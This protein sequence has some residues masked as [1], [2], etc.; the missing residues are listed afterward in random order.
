MSEVNYDV[1]YTEDRN[2]LTTA[3]RI[4]LAIPHLIVMGVWGYLAELLA[5]IQWF[6]IL[7]TGKRNEGMFKLQNQW[8][9]Y[10]SRVI[11]Y[12]SLMFDPYPPF[13]TEEGATG[14]TYGLRYEEPAN[15]LTN[16]LRFIWAIP[17]MLILAVLAIGAY[18]V[19]I[20][21]WFAIV[22]TGKHP[23]G[24]FDFML[25][26]LRF[27]VQTYAYM[28]LMTDTYPKFG[29]GAGAVAA[30]YPAAPYPTAQPI[31]SPPAAY[32]SAPPPPAQY[33]TAPPPPAAPPVA[34][35][36]APPVP[37]PPPGQWSPP[38]AG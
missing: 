6:V 33:P 22:I 21:S 1:R 8:L 18:V 26:V 10:A 36:P 35:P 38:G 16:G 14:V 19:G 2:R 29:D 20:I 24:M 34:P 37:P 27:A 4:I 32:P 3:F 13:G 11:G 9:G 5:V 12:Y 25:K 30:P 17:A 7:F 15:R 31:A 28:F 23:R